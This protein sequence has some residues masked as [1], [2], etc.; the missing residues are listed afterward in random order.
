MM[1]ATRWRVPA[2]E[3]VMGSFGRR[4]GWVERNGGVERNGWVELTGWVELL[5]AQEAC[6][7]GAV[8]FRV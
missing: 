7:G 2:A 3:V 6:G 1:T 5:T 8:C 4:L